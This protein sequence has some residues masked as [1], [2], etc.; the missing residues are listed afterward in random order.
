MDGGLQ[1]L[2]Y[3]ERLKIFASTSTSENDKGKI[4]G[5]SRR[6]YKLCVSRFLFAK[7]TLIF[8]KRFL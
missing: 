2:S 7:R 4:G 3:K 6:F 1:K 8:F 5:F